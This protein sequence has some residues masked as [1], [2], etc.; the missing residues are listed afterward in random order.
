MRF[1]AAPLARQ[2][3][4]DEIFIVAEILKRRRYAA[5]VVVPAQTEML[6]FVH[7]RGWLDYVRFRVLVCVG[8]ALTLLKASLMTCFHS[9]GYAVVVV[10]VAVTAV[11]WKLIIFLQLT[12][13]VFFQL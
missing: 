4:I 12:A 1:D 8:V 10:L 5:L 6:C 3:H 7:L 11:I 9:Y 13:V 2:C